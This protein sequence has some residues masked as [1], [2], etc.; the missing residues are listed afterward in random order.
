M[1]LVVY[2]QYYRAKSA[3]RQQELDE[4]LRRNL[5]HPGI[6]RVMLFLESDSPPLP[7]ATVP[8]EIIRS[9]ERMTYAAWFRWVQKQDDG[10]A[11]L[12]NS[13]IYLDEGLENLRQTF[14][15]PDVFLAL[16]RYN[17]RLQ[18]LHLNDYPHWTQDVWGVRA[19]A[20]LPESLLHTSSFPLGFPGCDNRIAYV[21]WSHGFH[22]RNPSYHVR[23]VHLQASTARSYDKIGDRLY[24]GVSYVHPSLA[25]NED[26]E[27]EYTIWTRSE[28]RP[29]GVLIN[30]Q[31]VD[32]GVHQLM[33]AEQQEA[34]RFHN[35]QQ[36]TGLSW[37]HEAIGSAHIDNAGNAFRSEDT[38]F[39]PMPNLLE[40]GVSL[41]LRQPTR[42][43]AFT[44]RMP[45]R[46]EEGYLLEI[47]AQTEEG[48]MITI[49]N[50][51][52]LAIRP[53]G[54]RQFWQPNELKI[55]QLTCLH[56]RIKGPVA[57]PSWSPK[58]GAELVLF[59]EDGSLLQA[60]SL[61]VIAEPA[62]VNQASNAESQPQPS[63]GE[64]LQ[65][66]RWGRRS[67]MASQLEQAET[68]HTY[69]RRFRILRQG[70]ELIF[71]DRFW[72]SLGVSS[73]GSVPCPLDD[74]LG[75]LL[76]GFG[77]PNL[78]LRPN[79]IADRKRFAADVNFW[80]YP[81]RTEGD[82][83]AVH[84]TLQEP[85]LK[86]SKLH[87]YVGL[88][89]ATWIDRTSWP[90]EI[91]NSYRQ[92]IETLRAE[93]NAY[94][95]ALKVHSVCQHIFW[96][97]YLSRFKQAG[98]DSLWLSHKPKDH[99]NIDGIELRPWHLY[100][101]N[102]R[103]ANR[104]LNLSIKPVQL[105]PWLAS[106]VG[107]HMDH[108]ITDV[109]PRLQQLKDLHRFHIHLQEE[110]HFNPIV[111][112]EQVGDPSQLWRQGVSLNQVD[113]K[114]FFKVDE[115]ATEK[116]LRR[117]NTIISDSVF[118]L[119]PAGAGPNSLRLWESLT[120]GCVPVI[121][122]DHL[123]MPDIKRISAGKFTDWADIVLFHPESDLET[124]P[125]RLESIEA[126]E[127]QQRSMRAIEIMEFINRSTCLVQP[128]LRQL[129][130]LKQEDSLDLSK[131]RI[132][133]PMYGP[134]DGWFWRS[135]K[136]G[137][138]NVVI[139]WYLRGYVNITFGWQGHFW[140][141]GFGEILLMERD[142]VHDLLDRKKD[143]PRWQGEVPYKY[144]FF[145]NQYHLAN[146][147]NHTSTYFTYAADHLEKIRSSL[148]RISYKQRIHAS[149][150]AGSIE[151][152]VQEF[153]RNRFRGWEDFIEIYSCADKL[154]QKEPHRYSVDEYFRLVA[155]SKFGVS[156]RG[157]GPKCFREIEYLAFGTPL[158]ITEGVEVNYTNLLEEGVHYFR[159]HN[160]DDIQRIVESTTEET[161]E[162][163]S[164]ACWQWFE[165]HG[166]LDQMFAELQ[167]RISQL[168]LAATR[169]QLVRIATSRELAEV[170]LAARSLAVVDP[171][172]Q[173]IAEDEPGEAPLELK[174]D[175]LVVN[176][177]PFVDKEDAYVWRVVPEEQ[178][179]YTESILNS[180]L[181]VHK[182]L[183]ELLGLRLRNFRITLNGP[184]GN[185]PLWDRLEHQKIVLRSDQE[186]ALLQIDFDWSRRCSARYIDRQIVINGPMAVT[187]IRIAEVTLHYETEQG[188]TTAD[189]TDHFNDYFAM[190]GELIPEEKVIRVCKL[191]EYGDS[192]FKSVSGY[193][194]INRDQVNHFSYNNLQW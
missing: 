104:R 45:R 168:D 101:V 49:G 127:L 185:I 87:I 100:A 155:S 130:T 176:E 125:D 76:W 50:D 57:V 32:K 4:C 141:G 111:Y 41:Q 53:G 15:R 85:Q 188:N 81:C 93:L 157:N 43:M 31:A 26:A 84:Q 133:I 2:T 61:D 103:E 142:N 124:L 192:K 117:Y 144:A 113:D 137:F 6:N 108:Y 33:H 118:S 54:S 29:A 179:A 12:L 62:S 190:H 110:W 73:V 35:L 181:D 143:P 89:W 107:A 126:S 10:I 172:A 134:K 11:L 27:L 115:S 167:Q 145:S 21:M 74:H 138:Y 66:Y 30:Q 148:G 171:R 109:R 156:F 164:Q 169:H 7:T 78:E 160:P 116:D 121:L 122:S 23:S 56:M 135:R 98:I 18:G 16:T 13:D 58:E 184:T 90:E 114:Q 159:A 146:G 91:L 9:N 151:N 128:S 24:G 38:I 20:E 187:F 68:I 97:K 102:A 183:L 34:Q 120:I 129:P 149:I 150:F 3:D 136:H 47:E 178:R 182:R 147:R 79:Q 86:D 119:C 75:L 83:F 96:D 131:P 189:L 60:K 112:G 19:D 25:P 165:S 166:T 191:W 64:R 55:N 22:V 40:G 37:V 94:G 46:S 152:E 161:W 105:R 17:P 82:A 80:Q 59:G 52:A 14:D 177:L 72:P 174:A 63:K 132:V 42:L 123:V 173:W 44:L 1:D 194:V 8:V 99:D 65:T 71:D 139:E 154:N 186:R 70:D 106:F 48:D 28:E 193:S 163:M 170:S 180:D 5:N 67:A 95:I 69:G 39:L 162:Q 175:D 140:W 36:F 158:I 92:R 51:S 77:Q 88:P 153:F